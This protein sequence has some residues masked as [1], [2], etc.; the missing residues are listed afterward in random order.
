MYTEIRSVRGNRSENNNCMIT[1]TVTS[2]FTSETF[3]QK[4]DKSSN[5]E[6]FR[7]QNL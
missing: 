2:T 4:F 7:F 6:F 3:A 1:V 5:T